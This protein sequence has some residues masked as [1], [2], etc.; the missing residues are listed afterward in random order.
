MACPMGPGAAVLSP[1]HPSPNAES[2][3]QHS[4]LQYATQAARWCLHACTP[5]LCL[6]I[7]PSYVQ[8]LQAFTPTAAVLLPQKSRTILHYFSCHPLRY[9][10]GEY[11]RVHFDARPLGDSQGASAWLAAG[12]QRLVQIVVYLNTMSAAQGGATAFHHP[13]L[14]GLS[15]QPEQGAA[16]V[17]FPALADGAVDERMAH[18]GEPVVEGEKWIIN[19]WAMQ[20]SKDKV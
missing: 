6:S 4:N 9:F 2:T 11:Q 8:R 17:F 19:T 20:Y 18:S 5:L 3:V 16:L 12:G 7:K 10:E 15:V 1:G 13:V 14:K